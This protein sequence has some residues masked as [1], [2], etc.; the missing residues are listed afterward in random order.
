[1]TPP[2]S[3]Q[4]VAT[5]F[6]RLEVS[7]T[8]APTSMTSTRPLPPGATVVPEA[9]WTYRTD[10]DAAFRF[11]VV[12]MNHQSEGGT[13]VMVRGA[14]KFGDP[15]MSAYRWLTGIG[16]HAALTRSGDGAGVAVAARRGHEIVLVLLH[17]VDATVADEVLIGL[18]S[19]AFVS[20]WG[21]S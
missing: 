12:V 6:G 3:P 2:L 5:A 19:E 4:Q 9:K 16:D 7:V 15:D 1:M 20:S 10:A 21:G 8:R 14:A 11:V 17:T 18:A 13:E